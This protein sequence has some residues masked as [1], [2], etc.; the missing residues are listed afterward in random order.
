VIGLVDLTGLLLSLVTLA[1]LTRT[2]GWRIKG[3]DHL[4][5]L[6]IV[7]L[8]VIINVGN[9]LEWSGIT[10]FMDSFE[11]YLHVLMAAA[12]GFFLFFLVLARFEAAQKDTREKY[13]LLFESNPLP[14]MVLEEETLDF[15]DV[16]DAAVAQYG[17]TREEFLTLNAAGIRP[18]EDVEKA[19]QR[20]RSMD[21][22]QDKLGVWRHRK[23]DGTVFMVEIFSHRLE[24]D[25]RPARLVLCSDVT[26]RIEAE[27]AL[28]ESEE[29]FRTS[30]R[31]SPDPMVI[32]RMRD[33][34]I[35]DA[36]EGFFSS[37]GYGKDEVLGRTPLEIGLWGDPDDRG[38]FYDELGKRGSVDNQEADFNLRDG[39]VRSGLVSAR[40]MSLLGDEH[41]I[42]MIKDIT[43]LKEIQTQLRASVNEKDVLLR[44][45]HH[46]VKNNLQVISGLLDL[47]GRH[48]R[49]V[50]GKDVYRESQ[51]RIITM[52]LIHEELYRARDLARVDFGAYVEN[53]ANHLWSSYG[54][55]R[56]QIHL[57]LSVEKAE[58]VV[59]TAIPCGLIVN[60]LVSNALA[61]AF[62]AGRRGEVLI[63]FRNVDET[64]YE[65]EI[66]DDGVGLP[67][68]LDIKELSTMGLKLVTVL[69]QQLG[70][71]L[72]I[73]R[74]GGTRFLLSFDQYLEAGTEMY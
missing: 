33:G 39:S 62:P 19:V 14:M 25:G 57:D 69:S 51:N 56:D 68:D 27:Q 71:Q 17:Y 2:F 73:E 45:I 26:G 30:F 22:P 7:V 15:L 74:Q 41:L 5:I 20:M 38:R 70:A 35:V 29:R 50:P 13:R 16:N 28:A 34:A 32:L 55:D 24:Y 4:M 8:A 18:S 37:S 10:P 54:V 60:E 58:M 59:D 9:F 46:R 49:E 6:G 52:A 12:W 61:H 42:I 65:L 23:K 66:G 3:Y 64:R 44:E 21:G 43:R 40:K 63:R 11:D 47:Q 31:I 1:V 67:P 72:Q 53:L 36:N 48:A